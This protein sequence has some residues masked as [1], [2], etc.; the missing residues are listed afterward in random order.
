MANGSADKNKRSRKHRRNTRNLQS[1]YAQR[2]RTN[3]WLETHLW[4]T[5]RMKMC[6][7]YGYQLSKHCSDKGVRAAY[8]SLTHGCLISVSTEEVSRY[9]FSLHGFP[10]LHFCCNQ[11]Q[12]VF[13]QGISLKSVLTNTHQCL[14]YIIFSPSQDISYFSCVEVTGIQ[15]NVIKCLAPLFNSETGK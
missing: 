10:L 6:S 1:T 15:T 3:K 9:S 4:H 13:S 5:R 11:F 12:V 14:H 8:K 7:K 2:Q